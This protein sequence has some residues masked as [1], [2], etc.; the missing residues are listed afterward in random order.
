MR[1]LA[2]LLVVMMGGCAASPCDRICARIEAC[3]FGD[4]GG[5]ECV[6]ICVLSETRGMARADE[7]PACVACME[8]TCDVAAS[9]I[10]SN[11]TDLDGPC[12]YLER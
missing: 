2:G 7:I 3:S 5:T 10:S 4:G 12:A 8:S 9:C 11:G 6:E 1:T